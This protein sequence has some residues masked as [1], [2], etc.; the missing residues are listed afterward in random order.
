L[1]AVCAVAVDLT[2]TI[3][4][5]SRYKEQ[6]KSQSWLLSRFMDWHE[7]TAAEMDMHTSNPLLDKLGKSRD[8]LYDKAGFDR[9]LGQVDA[10]SQ[11]QQLAPQQRSALMNQ[12]ENLKKLLQNPDML[13]VINSSEIQ[14]LIKQSG[15]GDAAA[16]MQLSKHPDINKLLSDP[17]MYKQI[18]SLN[19]SKL[20]AEHKSLSGTDAK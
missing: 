3:I 9:L 15:Q 7:S 1:W 4:E 17:A 11:I 5:Q 6:V 13:K 18:M 12:D 20:M 19:P 16:L 2:A 8:W 14:K 10:I